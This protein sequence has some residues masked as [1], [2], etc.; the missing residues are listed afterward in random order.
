MKNTPVLVARATVALAVIT[1]GA[2]LLSLGCHHT[3]TP[4]VT[5]RQPT[6]SVTPPA[7]TPPAG[8]GSPTATVKPP[9]DGGVIYTVSA[10][11]GD[12]NDLAP[13]HAHLARSL[14]PARDAVKE[15]MRANDSP[16]P[17][18][19]TLRGIKIADGLATVDF[20]DAF[21]ANFHGGSTEEAQT[22]NSILGTLGQFPTIERVQIL[23]EGKPIEALSQLPLNDPLPVIRPKTSLAARQGGGSGGG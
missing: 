15:L 17:S 1:G 22:V 19:T 11:G 5:G 18:G 8:E 10:K 21:Q 14:N 9:K 2:S 16:I 20:S 3:P 6:P 4:V 13:R 23:V 7:D 12:D